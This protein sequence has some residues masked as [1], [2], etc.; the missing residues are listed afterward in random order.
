MSEFYNLPYD[1][2]QSVIIEDFLKFLR[3]AKEDKNLAESTILKNDEET[4]D[5]LHYS[6]FIEKCGRKVHADLN[7]KIGTV[8]KERRIAKSVREEMEPIVKWIDSNPSVI[9]SLEM[10][11]GEMRKLEDRRTVK[12][13]YPRTKILDD[14]PPI[15][16]VA[17]SIQKPQLSEKTII[18][19]ENRPLL[20]EKHGKGKRKKKH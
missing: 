19:N 2:A 7:I 3:N 14:F 9:K 20:Y 11:L 6:E 15:E 4:Q 10:L 17:E 1:Q 16:G 5:L 12:R 13:Y 8:R 18:K